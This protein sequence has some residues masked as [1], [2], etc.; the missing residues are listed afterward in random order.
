[1]IKIKLALLGAV[2]LF[3]GCKDSTG[4]NSIDSLPTSALAAGI[5]TPQ[6]LQNLA[7]GVLAQDRVTIAQSY[8]VWSDIIARDVLRLDQSES[9]YTSEFFVNPPDGSGFMG[10]AQW[11]NEYVTARAANG[12][13]IGLKNSPA[14][15]ADAGQK[16]AATGFMRT[17]KAVAYVRI[18]ELRDSLGIVI[19]GDDPK[20][21]DPLRCKTS[22]LAAISALLD[23]AYADLQAGTTLPFKLPSGWSSNGDYS[24]TANLILFNRGLKGKVENLR[25]FD[26]SA[27][28]GAAAAFQNALT[29]LNLALAGMAP[30]AA[31]LA[32][33][34]YYQ[35]NPNPPESFG[36]PLTDS[37]L[38][39]NNL[40][41]QEIQAG[42]QRAAHIVTRS[43]AATAQGYTTNYDLDAFVNTPSNLTRLNP[44]LMNA[45]LLIERAKAEIELNQL[46]PAATDLNIIRVVLGG[47]P[48]YA[49]FATQAAARTA[50]LYEQRYTLIGTGPQRWVTLRGYDLLKTLPPMSTTD[51]YPQ[52]FPIPQGEVN[53][54]NNNITCS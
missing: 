3:A 23:S 5:T 45:D 14:T 36:N 48:P 34:P 1:M 10:S 28:G 26:R 12:V 46:G 38:H 18:A 7:T 29:A 19:Q 39:L 11:T 22:A 42:D 47:L 52:A 35:Y 20:T 27:S 41:A 9:R 17:I 43:S 53:A 13:I 25:G 37:K 6:V 2:A 30:T 15:V 21:V 8:L 31:G 24:T 4:V 49:A 40:F 32:Q 44:I 50:L 16:S 33:G 54:R 51:P